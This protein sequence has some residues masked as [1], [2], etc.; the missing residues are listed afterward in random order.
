MTALRTGR[1]LRLGSANLL[2]GRSLTDGVID[3]ERLVEAVRLL[4][5][6]LLAVQEVDRW[7]PRSNGIDQSG[8]IARTLGA[9][10]HRFVATV[11]GTPGISGWTPSVNPPSGHPPSS[12][13][14]PGN[15]P[16]DESPGPEMLSAQFGIALFS[17]L[18]VAEWHVL[19]LSPA[20]GRFPLPIPSQP[21]Q[22]LWLNDEPRAV[23]AAV[24]EHPRITIA[25][26]HL[27]FVP[28]TT[29]RQLT[30]VRRWLATLPGPQLLLGDLN[31]PG[32]VIRR[33][34]GWTPLVSSPTFP[35]SAPRVQLDHALAAGLPVGTRALGRIKQLP[36]SDHRAVLIDLDLPTP[37]G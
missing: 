8:L 36:I 26:T 14:P 28:T 12:N 15:P 34:G 18:P 13:R 4:E 2:S 11:E 9:V 22:V 10:D 23:V 19:R 31:L 32:S 3:T 17:R 16:V 33:V 7:Q 21:P 1:A 27:S 25:C 37:L 24:L 5:V 30:A 6:D 20:R 35:S 29:I